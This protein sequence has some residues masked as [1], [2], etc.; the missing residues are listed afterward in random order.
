[1]RI[2]TSRAWPTRFIADMK[3]VGQDV[4]PR[5]WRAALKIVQDTVET[6]PAVLARVRELTKRPKK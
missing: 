2:R 5:D 6:P 4:D 3:K 1:M